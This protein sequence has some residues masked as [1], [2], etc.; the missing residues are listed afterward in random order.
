MAIEVAAGP[1]AG[2]EAVD[3]DELW[4]LVDALAGHGAAVGGGGDRYDAQF[5]VDAPDVGAAMA[6]ALRVWRRAVAAARLPAWPIVRSQLLTADEQEAELA[7]PHPVLVGV[8]EIAGLLGTTRNRAWQVTRKPDFPRPL[9]VL[10]GGPV[11]ALPMV[12]R[13]LEEW[14]RRR[15]PAPGSK[16]AVGS[17]HGQSDASRAAPSLAP[18]RPAY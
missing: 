14:P 6:K 8:S 12:A 3:V 11:W 1:D 10:A 15:G 7:R 9:A 18:R 4:R 5:S 17:G 2:A 13:F 16:R